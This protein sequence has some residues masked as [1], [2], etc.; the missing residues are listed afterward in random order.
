[1]PFAA[2]VSEHPI[3]AHAVGEVT[4]HVLEQIGES[5]DLVLV[6]VTP[7][8]AGAL[9]DIDDAVRTILSPSVL[10]GCAATSVVGTGREVEGGPG[11]S[12]WAGR[13]GPVLPVRLQV[14]PLGEGAAVLTGWPE[15]I[16]FD[17]SLLMLVADPFSFPAESVFP[18][19]EERLPGLP[20]VGGMASAGQGPGGNRLVIDGTV[21]T[22]GAV[23]ALIGPG[24]DTEA[25]VSQG[26]RPVG[27]PFA[28]TRSD[29]S[30]LWELGGRPAVQRLRELAEQDLTDS[31]SA[32]VKAGAVHIG[33][34][35]DENRAEFGRGDFLV[36]NL[37]GGSPEE[38]W[39]RVNDRPELGSTVQFQLRDAES[40]DEDLR[41]ALRGRQAEAALLFTCN[42][43]G[44]RLFGEPDHDVTV[45][46]DT[47]ASPPVAGFFAQGEFGP[48]GG[49]N[50]VHGFSASLALLRGRDEPGRG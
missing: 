35:V 48:V 6:F 36:R 49:R 30:V 50:F 45:V 9:E 23:G 28:I 5:I 14:E 12:L 2:A 29:G 43:R 37:V 33:R 10:V 7:H 44:R 32:G 24:V 39:L 34:L 22:A 25:V 42:G 21:V 47:L 3:T 1:M 27:Q 17:P 38:G 46:A 11:I 19:V 8:H 20:V 4:G 26:C 40:A 18:V 41:E 13:F 31:E 15:R 16:P